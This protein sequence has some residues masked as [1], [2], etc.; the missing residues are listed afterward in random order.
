[1]I[2]NE[3]KNIRIF[4]DNLVNNNNDKYKIIVNGIEEELCSFYNDD[5]ISLKIIY[6]KLN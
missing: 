3:N 1:M 6:L 5:N 4:G 2:D